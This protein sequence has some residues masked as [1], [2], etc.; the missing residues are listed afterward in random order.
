MSTRRGRSVALAAVVFAFA[1]AL[2]V[3]SAARIGP[4]RPTSVERN[5]RLDAADASA[6]TTVVSST[7]STSTK[8]VGAT[9][10]RAIDPMAIERISWQPNAAVYRGFLTEEECDHLI[11]LASPTLKASTVVDVSTG[12][13]MSSSIRTSSG[14]FLVKGEDEI[15]A[16]IERRIASWTHVPI[17][18]GEGFQVLRYELG[19]EYRPHYD[20]FHDNVNTQ[21]EK[22]GQRVATVLMYLSDVD[23]GGETIFPDAKDGE[24]ATSEATSCAAG[25]L[26]VRPK[27]GDALFFMSLHHN[28]TQDLSSN[29]GGCPVIQGVKYSATKWMHVAPIQDATAGVK[30]PP[31]VCKDV[32][33]SC[34]AWAKSGECKKNPTFM[35]GR[36]QANGSCMRS[37]GACPPGTRDA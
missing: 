31:G 27:R 35:V 20:Y 8:G 37:C 32:N 18:H 4:N 7:P 33:P 24:R 15:V 12:G 3:V 5:A 11:A 19:Q 28:R 21:R 23:R 13:S 34:K 9:R 30:F 29:H 22:G 14:M 16:S 10:D 36:N 26:A 25:K 2:G 6:S 1:F 17:E